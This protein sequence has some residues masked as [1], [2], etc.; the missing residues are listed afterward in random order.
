MKSYSNMAWVLV[1]S[2]NEVRQLVKVIVQVVRPLDIAAV[3][4]Y[5]NVALRP[6]HLNVSAIKARQ[7]ALDL[8]HGALSGDFVTRNSG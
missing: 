3:R 8:R 4:H 1:P 7:R 6:D 2:V 5:K